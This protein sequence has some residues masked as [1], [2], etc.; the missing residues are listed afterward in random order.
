MARTLPWGVR[1]LLVAV[2]AVLVVLVG[3]ASWLV[4]DELRLPAAEPANPKPAVDG[5][6]GLNVLTFNVWHGGSQIPDGAQAIADIIRETDA[7]VTFMPEVGRAPA[8]VGRLLGYD[9][10]FGTD[11]G[12]VSRYPV[13]STAE[14]GT[15]WSKAVI[16]V[17]GTEV[18]VYGGH[19]EYRWYTT[20]LPRG[21]GGKVKGDWPDGSGSWDRLGAP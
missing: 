19:L 5:V 21:Y 17:N 9:H 2:V 8:K 1:W 14:V 4:Y 15:W 11:T 10:Y 13:I 16:D 7:D 3:L 12:I 20:Y 6:S 18:A